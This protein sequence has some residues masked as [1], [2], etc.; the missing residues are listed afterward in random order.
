[1]ALV[2]KEHHLSMKSTLV[3]MSYP[4]STF[5]EERRQHGFNLE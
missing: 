1:M 4:N 5:F 3:I 2:R